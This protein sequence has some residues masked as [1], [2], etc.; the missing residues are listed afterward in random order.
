MFPIP[1]QFGSYQFSLSLFFFVCAE[2]NCFG[3]SRRLENEWGDDTIYTREMHK[4][5]EERLFAKLLE[6]I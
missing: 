3:F 2:F 6:L 1:L 4:A 5:V